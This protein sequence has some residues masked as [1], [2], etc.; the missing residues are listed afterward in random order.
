MELPKKFSIGNT[1]YTVNVRPGPVYGLAFGRLGT[2]YGGVNYTTRT[3]YI[4][5][6]HPTTNAKLSKRIMAHTF[7]HEVTHAILKDMDHPFERN[8]AFVDN[9]AR[10]LNDVVHTAKL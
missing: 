3:V 4:A 5:T 2:H 10:R 9:F 6:K 8:E 1:R 7:W